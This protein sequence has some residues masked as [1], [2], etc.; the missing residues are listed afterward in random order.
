MARFLLP[1]FWPRRPTGCPSAAASAAKRC[2][3]AD[4][5]VR[6]AVGCTGWLGGESRFRFTSVDL[7]R[8]KRYELHL[9]EQAKS[10]ARR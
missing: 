2:Q 3:N 5:L 10:G 7:L 6:E 1:R 4:D 8:A 9:F